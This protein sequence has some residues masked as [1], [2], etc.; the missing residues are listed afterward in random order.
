MTSWVL[1]HHLDNLLCGHDLLAHLVFS[2]GLLRRVLDSI[3]ATEANFEF[4]LVGRTLHHWELR[5][6]T[7]FAVIALIVEAENVLILTHDLGHMKAVEADMIVA[8]L[9]HLE[10]DILLFATLIADNLFFDQSARVPL[11]AE[12]ELGTHRCVILPLFNAT[13]LAHIV[14]AHEATKQV[15]FLI[16]ANLANSALKVRVFFDPRLLELKPVAFRVLNVFPFLYLF[17]ILLVWVLFILFVADH[18]EHSILHLKFL[19]FA[20]SGGFL[21]DILCLNLG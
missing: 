21:L 15:A 1:A 4:A 6:V 20:R 16:C 11:R 17:L 8:F 10:L 5:I 3:R 19:G 14:F 18:K 2:F 7:K 13:F 12:V 9:A